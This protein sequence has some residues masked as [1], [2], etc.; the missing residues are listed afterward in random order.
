[1]LSLF[2]KRYSR[3]RFDAAHLPA[4]RLPKVTASNSF[5]VITLGLFANLIQLILNWSLDI[6][7]AVSL[8]AKLVQ[9]KLSSN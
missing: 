9:D 6:Y 1:M 8:T 7:S 3:V 4:L 2:G 5:N